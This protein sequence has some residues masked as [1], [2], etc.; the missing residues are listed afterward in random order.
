MRGHGPIL[1]RRP[2][3]SYIENGIKLKRIV[4]IELSRD[5][6]QTQA[7]TMFYS[8]FNRN[9]IRLL[10]KTHLPTTTKHKPKL[11]VDRLS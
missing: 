11:Y 6:I 4:S 5:S 8:L 3:R 2:V 10:A 1:V 7:R 9:H